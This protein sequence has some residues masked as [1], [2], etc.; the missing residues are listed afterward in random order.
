[1][2]VEWCPASYNRVGHHHQRW[3]GL[4]V[5]HLTEHKPL[6]QFGADETNPPDSG[7]NDMC[8]E[9]EHDYDSLA[10]EIDLE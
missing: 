1:M 10:D 9:C 7:E 8:F 5:P 2:G 4:V 3:T 6:T